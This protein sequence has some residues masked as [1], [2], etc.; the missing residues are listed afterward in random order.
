MSSSLYFDTDD[1]KASCLEKTIPPPVPRIKPMRAPNVCI[2]ILVLPPSM[3][4][5]VNVRLLEK[6]REELL[7]KEILITNYS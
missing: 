2:P 7:N 1:F 6:N 5:V 4:S 3:R